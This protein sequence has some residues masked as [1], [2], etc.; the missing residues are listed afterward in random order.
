MPSRRW[1]IVAGC[2]LWAGLIFATSSTVVTPQAFFAWF[3]ENVFTTD[4]SFERFRLFWGA[5]WL[6]VVKGWHVTEFA[7]LT[8]LATWT[9]DVVTQRRTRS[10]VLIAGALAIFYA[11][12]E[13]AGTR[14]D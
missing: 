6:F 8:V 2:F 5:C 7:I 9:I 12:R 14:A 4:E 10:N 1:G 11:A 13:E 3:S